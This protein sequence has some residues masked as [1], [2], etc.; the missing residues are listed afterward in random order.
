MAIS[1]S[2]L[3]K[4]K[5][6]LDVAIENFKQAQT[7]L[8]VAIEAGDSLKIERAKVNF[9]EKQLEL[10]TQQRIYNELLLEYNSQED[11]IDDFLGVIDN[12]SSNADRYKFMGRDI[13]Q[14]V[15]SLSKE[16]ANLLKLELELNSEKTLLD[17]CIALFMKKFDI[18]LGLVKELS[19]DEYLIS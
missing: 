6:V 9:E 15:D 10:N 13:N 8:D 12:V 4:Q 7:D 18:N 1:N 5:D 19:K 3:Q 17:F 14:D 2:D 11:K 16:Q